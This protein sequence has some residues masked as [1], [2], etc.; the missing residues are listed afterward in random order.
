MKNLFSAAPISAKCTCT[1]MYRALSSSTIWSL[2]A[3]FNVLEVGTRGP[4]FWI[5]P[6]RLIQHEPEPKY[7]WLGHWSSL[8]CTP[9]FS[10]NESGS[11]GF[12]VGSLFLTI[13]HLG[14]ISLETV[15]APTSEPIGVLKL[16][17]TR[18]SATKQLCFDYPS[19]L[20]LA[21]PSSYSC[22]NLYRSCHST[23]VVGSQLQTYH[24]WIRRYQKPATSSL[25]KTQ[26]AW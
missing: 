2:I 18:L 9:I 19:K 11:R 25:V 5:P 16:N 4:F 13:P 26:R 14:G 8:V 17:R 23:G 6:L 22:T 20:Q 10:T 12:N 21:Y 1:D 24:I 15:K 3:G 7:G